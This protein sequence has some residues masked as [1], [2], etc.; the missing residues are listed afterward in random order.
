MVENQS[1]AKTGILLPGRIFLPTGKKFYGETRVD[2][3]EPK[4]V[5]KFIFWRSQQTLRQTGKTIPR[6]TIEMI[7]LKTIFKRLR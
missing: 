7:A 2:R 1:R 3:I 5:E 6:D 4:D